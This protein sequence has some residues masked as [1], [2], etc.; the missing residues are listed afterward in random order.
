MSGPE[1]LFAKAD[2]RKGHA[3]AKERCCSPKS[4]ERM[5][6]SA[7]KC[8]DMLILYCVYFVAYNV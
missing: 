6:V 3:L 5:N 4:K 8:L 1:R 7:L 2:H